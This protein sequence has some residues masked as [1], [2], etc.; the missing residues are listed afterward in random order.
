[1]MT[2]VGYMYKNVV[3]KPDWIKVENVHDI[4]SVSGC[5]SSQFS[6]FINYWKHNGYWFF[7]SSSIMRKIAEENNLD[8]SNTTLFYY[9]VYKF[10]FDEI[11]KEWLLFRPDDFDTN[12]ENPTTKVL[13]GF[14][15]VTFS[16]HTSP[17]CSPLSCNYLAKDISV[18]SHCLFSSF[19]EAK[20][21]LENGFFDNS[22]CGP[23]RIFSVYKV[24]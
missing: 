22:E 21:A 11:T 5:T 9:E 7:N 23:F 18:N 2:P 16:V 13:A 1:M 4:Y 20:E 17:E 24:G 19:I 6:D 8:I 15:V 14:D 12:I 3:P 10:E